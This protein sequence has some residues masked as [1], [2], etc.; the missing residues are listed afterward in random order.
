MGCRALVVYASRFGSTA[1]V[2]DAIAE[3]LRAGGWSI[4]VSSVD[5]AAAPDA[6]DAVVIGSAVYNARWMPE[7]LDY[8][9][10]NQNGLNERPTAY[11]QVCL[12]VLHTNELKQHIIDAWMEPANRLAPPVSAATFAGAIDRKNIT[13][14]MRLL[15]WMSRIPDGDYRDWDAIRSWGNALS[16]L[17]TDR[18]ACVV[19]TAQR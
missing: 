10:R 18:S 6:Y 14:S 1:G 19:T 7:A 15:V 12:S 13:G 4:D 5:D 3:E 2:A 17:L 9:R 16:T 11:F 8:V